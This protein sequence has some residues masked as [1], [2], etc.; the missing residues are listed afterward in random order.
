MMTDEKVKIVIL[1]AGKGVR[2]K[3]KL[4]KVL[5]PLGGKHMIK[6]L[7]EAVDN[8]GIG[9]KPVIVVGY[10]KELVMKELGDKYEYVVQDE[11][12]GTGNAV[13]SAENAC[14]GAEVVIVLSG[15]QP[16]IKTETLKNLLAKHISSGA[17]ITI[18]TTMVPNFE[19]WYQAFWQ[20]GR[21]IR[22]DDKIIDKE[23]K[24][25]S[26]AEKKIK[27]LNVS[28]YAFEATWLWKNIRLLD[29]NLNS[30]KEL[31]LTDLWQFASV[32]KEKIESI[33][34]SP[35]EAL[36]AN[37]KEELEMLEQFVVE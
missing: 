8:A 35:E 18:T 32:N 29:K 26:I 1:A 27:E 11:Q 15:D 3:S 12:L 10:K 4:P 34:I 24:D 31:Y 21:I 17:K 19:D 16:F 28:C 9:G 5:V 2:M 6:H 14:A 37:S 30:Q 7:L 36:G 23:F 25:A 13:H 33:E 20:Y 22:F